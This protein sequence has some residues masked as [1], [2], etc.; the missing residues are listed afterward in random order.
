MKKR[1]FGINIYWAFIIVSILLIFGFN[2]IGSFKFLTLA[3]L[4]FPLAIIVI[5]SILLAIIIELLPLPL[6]NP[7]KRI[8][9]VFGF[10]KTLYEKLGIK[11]WK[12]NIP[13]IKSKRT[14]FDKTEILS[15]RDPNYLLN[16]LQENCKAEVGHNISFI[17]S[18]L[19]ITIVHIVLP[20]N[21]ILFAWLP[22]AIISAYMHF[23]CSSVQRYMRPRLLN[24]LIICKRKEDFVEGD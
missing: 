15:P 14:G 24:L 13:T 1:I 11:K 4:T 8:F 23:L 9:K 10:E 2:L 5:P 20:D 6:F 19:S 22:V 18:F 3:Y 17:W 12:E 16:F 21:L 7:E